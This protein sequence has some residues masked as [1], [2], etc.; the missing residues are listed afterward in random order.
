KVLNYTT[1]IEGYNII[2]TYSPGEISGT[3]TKHWEDGNDHDGIRPESIKIQLYAN[4]EA[5]GEP[6][7]V[8]A[9]DNWTY[10]WEHLPITNKDGKVIH[11]SIKEIEVA[12]GYTATISGENIGNLLITNTHN[13]V[14]PNK[15]DQPTKP[16]G[17]TMQKVKK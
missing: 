10:T 1:K 9:K 6:V 8:K 7:K 14:T 11:Y 13:P 12:D 4:G 15:P 16:E 3:V 2:N 17:S 5:H